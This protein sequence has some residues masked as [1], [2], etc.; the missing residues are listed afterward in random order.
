MFDAGRQA[1]TTLV[2]MIICVISRTKSIRYIPETNNLACRRGIS[3]GVRQ[4]L[5]KC[6][7]KSL[8]FE[9]VSEFRYIL[10]CYQV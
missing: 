7:R 2:N 9:V 4:F 8:I 3:E 1:G 5:E 10:H 6:R